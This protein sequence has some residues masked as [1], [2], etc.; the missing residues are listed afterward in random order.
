MLLDVNSGGAFI[1]DEILQQAAMPEGDVW[2]QVSY[3]VT[4]KGNEAIH[5]WEPSSVVPRTAVERWEQRRTGFKYS[6]EEL[7][8]TNL[9]A[10]SL[11][12]TKRRRYSPTQASLRPY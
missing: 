6:A 11:K 9:C 3:G 1:L 12:E 5:V 8:L 7:E 4:G 2:Y 10:G